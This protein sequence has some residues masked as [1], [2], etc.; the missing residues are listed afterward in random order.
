MDRITW[1]S[2]AF[3]GTAALKAID[4]SP[5]DF[6]ASVFPRDFLANLSF[7]GPSTA[8]D[9]R[10]C[11]ILF[12]QSAGPAAVQRLYGLKGCL[13]LLP[14]GSDPGGLSRENAVLFPRNPKYAYARL[15]T[16]LFPLALQ[17]GS[18]AAE[19]LPG[20]RTDPG[21]VLEE[22]VTIEPFVTIGRDSVIGRGTHV[23]RGASIGPRV[24]IG[25]DCLIGEDSVV[26]EPGFGFAFDGD[27]P[28]IRM[29]HLGG[30]LV[31]DRTEIGSHA[32]VSSGTIDP[33]VLGPDVKINNHAHVGH[34]CRVGRGTLIGIGSSV[35]GSSRIGE[36]CWIS[37]GVLVRNKITVGD[38][39]TAGMGA[40]IVKDV[41]AY[42]T[43]VGLPA[44]PTGN[45]VPWYESE[46]GT[47]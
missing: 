21:F 39:V 18:F 47:P 16:L 29:P 3:S 15:M 17:R 19:P 35:S 28:P 9:P 10:D 25:E 32:T 13:I 31:G 23:M 38:G 22:G 2:L 44:K 30:I 20:V 43:V 14:A 40:V 46:K 26:G 24:Q 37:P 6:E 33:T 27:R 34:N 8:S 41:A 7:I 4:R 45:M 11:T 1:P 5:E 12:L 42:Q 36:R